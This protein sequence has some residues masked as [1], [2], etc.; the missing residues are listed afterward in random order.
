MLE[1]ASAIVTK[2]FF[3]NNGYRIHNYLE[4]VLNSWSMESIDTAFPTLASIKKVIL[5]NVFARSS[6]YTNEWAMF[7]VEF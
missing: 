2:C 4:I 5:L 1:W 3:R 7:L 6:S